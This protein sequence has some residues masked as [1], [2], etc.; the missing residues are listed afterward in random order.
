M[1]SVIKH[2]QAVSCMIEVD[3]GRLKWVQTLVYGETKGLDRR[4]LWV[5]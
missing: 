4:A 3:N 2:A 1:A 5:Y